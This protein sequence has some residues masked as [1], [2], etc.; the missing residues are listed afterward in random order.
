M[1][2]ADRLHRQLE[3]T[4]GIFWEFLPIIAL[5]VAYLLIARIGTILLINTG[6]DQ[7]TAS[8]QSLSA[9]TGTGF[10]TRASESVVGNEL[11]RRIVM[12]L[13]IIG[14][15]GLA[16]GV[17]ALISIFRRE[18]VEFN[19]VRAAALVL[20]LAAIFWISGR[21]RIWRRVNARLESYIQKRPMFRKSTAEEL[22]SFHDNYSIVEIQ[23]QENDNNVGKSLRDTDFRSRNI[24]VLSIDSNDEIIPMP[25]PDMKIESNDKLICFGNVESIADSLLQF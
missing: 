17:A 12:V 22:L 1:T 9:L 14:N 3:D 11:R 15:I 10:T 19:M 2:A 18:N 24:L 23:V 7:P 16:G 5:L 20:I 8:F 6:L 4:L 25:S 13:M 21:K